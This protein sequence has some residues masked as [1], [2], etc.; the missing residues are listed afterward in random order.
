MLPFRPSMTQHSHSG[1]SNSRGRSGRRRSPATVGFIPGAGNRDPAQVMGEVE[2]RIVDPLLGAVERVC[3]QY[4]S[5]PRYRL[6]P[7]CQKRFEPFQTGHGAVDDGDR[8]G[9]QAGLPIGVC[10]GEEARVQ[11]LSAVPFSVP[12]RCCPVPVSVAAPPSR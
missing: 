3:P 11:C 12:A 7:F 8:A 9:R 6:N 1:R 2:F 10:G 5:A 4:L